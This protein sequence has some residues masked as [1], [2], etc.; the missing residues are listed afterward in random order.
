MDLAQLCAVLQGCLSSNQQE[1]SAAEQLL[2]QVGFVPYIH[3]TFL[4][5]TRRADLLIV[6]HQHD[7]SRGQIVNLLRVAAEQS[8]AMGVRQVAAIS[9]KN[10]ARRD[11][12]PK[13]GRWVATNAKW[14][15]L[16]H[17]TLWL[18]SAGG[19]FVSLW[20]EHVARA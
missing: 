7:G 20:H 3:E 15:S 6:I 11:W 4:A 13:E 14:V 8:V 2:K 19:A 5:A 16:R 1:R 17:T 10:I 12:E 18:K 9:F